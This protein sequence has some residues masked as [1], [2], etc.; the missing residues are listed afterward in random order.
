[1]R[2]GRFQR[3]KR[4]QALVEMAIS[5][6]VLALILLGTIDMGRL[7]FEYIELRGAVREAAA[8]G[9]RAPQDSAG[10]EHAVYVH[11]PDLATGTDVDVEVSQDPSTIQVYENATV[12]VTATRI[13]TPFTLSFF[14]QFGLGSVTLTC[15]ATSRVWS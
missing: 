15:S 1:M 2:F 6:P 14:E 12:R 11:S 8:Y 7:F 3:A 5:M 10:M 13:F 9:A 4:G